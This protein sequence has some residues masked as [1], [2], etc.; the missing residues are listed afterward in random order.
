MVLV[1]CI[2]ADTNRYLMLLLVVPYDQALQTDA[3][4]RRGQASS[5]VMLL[6]GVKHNWEE[7]GQAALLAALIQGWILSRK[8]MKVTRLGEGDLVDH[9]GQF[10]KKNESGTSTPPP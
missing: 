1:S 4:I 3:A 5:D 7:P 6:D 8:D 9:L 2:A 10:R